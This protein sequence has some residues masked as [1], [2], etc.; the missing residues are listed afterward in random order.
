MAIFNSYVSLPEGS[1]NG[2]K[3]KNFLIHQA[4]IIE[5]SD[6]S[7]KNQRSQ[8]CPN[9]MMPHFGAFCDSCFL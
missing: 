6:S 8:S 1:E 2:Q 7:K 4:T 5:I 3:Y 9:E